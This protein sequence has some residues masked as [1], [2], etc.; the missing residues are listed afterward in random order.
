MA[1]FEGKGVVAVRVV[2]R[3]GR[4]L[5]EYP[6]VL[7]RAASPQSVYRRALTYADDHV[8]GDDVFGENVAFADINAGPYWVRATV[9]RHEFATAALVEPGRTTVV[10]L[11]LPLP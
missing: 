5:P 10:T 3:D 7:S 9:G 8:H 11:Q 2:D 4:L 6:I 1:P